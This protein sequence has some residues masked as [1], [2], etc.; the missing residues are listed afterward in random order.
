[1]TTPYTGDGLPRISA[2]ERGMAT[3]AQI[4]ALEPDLAQCASCWKAFDDE[5][6]TQTGYGPMCE[7]CLAI[8]VEKDGEHE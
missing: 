5:D 6:L 8:A 4:A 2:A 3:D 1:M 7:A